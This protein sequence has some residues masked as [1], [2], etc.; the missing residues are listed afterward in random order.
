MYLGFKLLHVLAVIAFLGNITTGVFWKAI[1]DRTGDRSIVAHTVRDIMRSDRFITVPSIVLL[2][3]GG[4][5]AAGAAGYSIL[6]TGWIVWALGLFI[7]S[8]LAFIPVARSQQ[9]MVAAAEAPVDGDPLASEPYRRASQTW[10][11][12]GLVA[13]VAPV[14]AAV[15]MILKPA[16]PSFPR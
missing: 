12:W 6:G 14:A 11:L 15:I 2:L 7:I 1:A 4:F 9:A 3:V 8:G 16:L 5:G 13:T 10:A